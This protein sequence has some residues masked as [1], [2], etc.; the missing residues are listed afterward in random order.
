MGKYGIIIFLFIWGLL[1]FLFTPITG[2]KFS[3]KKRLI[4][5]LSASFVIAT[6]VYIT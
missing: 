3:L 1:E 2:V 4:F 5:F 6:L